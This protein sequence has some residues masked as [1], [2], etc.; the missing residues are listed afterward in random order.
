MN[1]H[2]SKIVLYLA[3]ALMVGPFFILIA[4]SF[5]YSTRADREVWDFVFQFTLP[6]LFKNTFLLIFLTV[7]LSS[8]IGFGQ[9]VLVVLTDL[10]LKAI[11]HTIFVL[12]L[13]FPL[14]VLS[15]IYVGAFEYSGPISSYLREVLNWNLLTYINIKGPWAIAFI[16]SLA[17]SPY[18]YLFQK[19]FLER[20]DR[21]VIWSA[22]TL[23]KGP[24]GLLFSVIIPQCFPWVLS[25]SI[26]VG[27]EVLC[28]FGGVSVF[29]FETFSTAIYESWVS[30]FSFKTAMKLSLFPMLLAIL[31]Y[32]F[33]SRLKDSLTEKE[34][35]NLEPIFYPGKLVKIIILFLVLSHCLLA[36]FFPIGQLIIWAMSSWRETFGENFFSYV[37]DTM[38]L[39]VLCSFFVGFISL[40]FVFLNRFYWG[41]RE[42]FLSL[43]LKLGY[44]VPG[45]IVGVGVMAILSMAKIH[46]FGPLAY[47][48]LMLGLLIRFYSVGF[49]MQNKAYT[50]INK[51]LDWVSRSLGL[52]PRQTFY[53]AHFSLLRPAIFSSMLLCFLEVAKE[54]PVTL[55]LRPHGVNTLSTKIYEL[56]SE[57]E[58]EKSSLYAIFL[59]G[60]GCLSVLINELGRN[61]KSL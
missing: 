21:R 60:F 29:N 43:F 54:M 10:K 6:H 9:A 17:L 20:M 58:W 42:K 19:S 38:A 2:C 31:L 3:L 8:I 40:A 36:I 37:F 30:L 28:D 1:W 35:M 15:Y 57:G 14:Y 59:I 13:V 11:L 53:Q 25:S 41:S 56:T 55:I 50:L 51:K 61:Q 52:N 33:N 22:R 32:W 12:P 7:F 5:T 49:E 16:F 4:K 18:V 48:A 27:L 46:F 24:W 45:T 39:A 26:L 44:A 23:G 47:I 34:T